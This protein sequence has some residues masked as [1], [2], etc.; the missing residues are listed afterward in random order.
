MTE[1]IFICVCEI[2]GGSLCVATEDGDRVR[3]RITPALREGRRVLLSFAGVE[4]LIPA[5]LSSAIGQLYGQFPE[6]QVDGLVECRDLP[7]NTQAAVV[8]SR[9]WAK[10][11]YRDPA[12][13][14]K[15]VHEVLGE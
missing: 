4:M 8:S 5:F 15:A 10:A 3:Q 11:Y 13:Y 14:E 6:D 1:P 12:G 2:V 7:D 9:R